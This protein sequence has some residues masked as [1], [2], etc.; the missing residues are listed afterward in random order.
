MYLDFLEQVVASHSGHTVVCDDEI[1]LHSLMIARRNGRERIGAASV[2]VNTGTQELQSFTTRINGS[3][4]VRG[5][6]E[7]PL[8]ELPIDEAVVDGQD[9]ELRLC[10]T[11]HLREWREMREIREQK[12]SHEGTAPSSSAATTGE[13]GEHGV[14]MRRRPS[15]TH[16]H[17]SK[18]RPYFFIP[19]KQRSPGPIPLQKRREQCEGREDLV[20]GKAMR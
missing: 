15:R 14:V 19:P 6:L 7:E 2:I 12:L 10:G 20:K 16:I 3:H 5:N 18:I 11:A 1:H 4:L 17:Q 9:V 13:E 8:D